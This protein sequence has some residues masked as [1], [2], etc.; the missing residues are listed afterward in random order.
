MSKRLTPGTA[1]CSRRFIRRWV[2]PEQRHTPLTVVVVALYTTVLMLSGA[3]AST[4]TA[5]ATMSPSLGKVSPSLG[6]Q[7]R[8][9]WNLNT[10]ELVSS[11]AAAGVTVAFLYTPPPEPSSALGE[12]LSRNDMR[13]VSAEI[14][15]LVTAYE[16][17]RTH[18]VA[19]KPSQGRHAEY[20]ET[21]P[22]YT[23]DRLL[24]DVRT[25]VQRDR[26]NPSV[27]GYWVLDDTPTWDFGSLRTVLTE[28]RRII[29]AELPTICGFSASL[30]SNGK[31]V[32][33]PGLAKNFTPNGC[34][35]AAPYI[36]ADSHDPEDPPLTDVDWS[37]SQ[38]IPKIKATLRQYGWDPARHGLL[39]VGQAWAGRKTSN[40]AVTDAPSPANMAA[41]ADAFCQAGAAGIAWYAWTITTRYSDVQTP[42]NH[43][44]LREGVQNSVGS[45]RSAG[46]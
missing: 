24:A 30:E 12:A 21:D 40:G 3:C 29:P 38:L 31:D 39:G 42:A 37:M 16:C 20:C 33:E 44:S 26:S 1:R 46:W 10:P 5:P 27:A 2:Q 34:D 23:R 11:A 8:G 6:K 32:W 18:T 41:Q 28:I 9:G 14:S 17:T 7:V 22:H 25:L 43:R 35:M 15:Q 13:I 19:P 45:C 4:A 36:Y